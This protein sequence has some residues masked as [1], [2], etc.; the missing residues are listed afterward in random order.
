M[1][2]EELGSLCVENLI[3]SARL[4]KI[5]VLIIHFVLVDIHLPQQTLLI[6]QISQ[7]AALVSPDA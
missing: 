6:R 1:M 7:I 4:P 3:R 2:I 5:P